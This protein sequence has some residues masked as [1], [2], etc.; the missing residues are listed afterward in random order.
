M[1][2]TDGAVIGSP[3]PITSRKSSGSPPLPSSAAT[4]LPRSSTL[5]PPIAMTTSAPLLRPVR[6]ASRAISTVGS[7][8][9]VTTSNG[10]G[11]APRSC[12]CRSGLVPVNTSALEPH[13]SI[14]AGSSVA[15]PGPNTTRC[16]VAK[17]KDGGPSPARA[18]AALLRRMHS[19]ELGGFPRSSHQL[20][21]RVAP[22][23]VVRGRLVIG[24]RLLVPVHLDQH[25]VRRIRLILHDIE[26]QNPRLGQRRPSVGLSWRSGNP[27]LDRGST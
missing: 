10:T 6:T 9:T 19:G 2:G 11:S 23:G 16:A 22:D 13:P 8:P 7:P 17:S 3:R 20:G 25:H 4:A 1:Y 27:A 21:D 14:S 18:P 5:P 26:A 24:G 15:R 12:A